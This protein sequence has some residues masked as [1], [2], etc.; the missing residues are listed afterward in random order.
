MMRVW[1]G[2]D[3]PD[4]ELTGGSEWALIS[5]EGISS[6][7]VE[8]DAQ[9]VAG[10]D[11]TAVKSPKLSPRIIT[12]NF[13]LIGDAQSARRE[14]LARLEPK[15]KIFLKFEDGKTLSIEGYVQNLTVSQDEPTERLEARIYCPDP[16]FRGEE[17]VTPDRTS[18]Y[19]FQ[20]DAKGQGF[21]LELKTTRKTSASTVV[22]NGVSWGLLAQS[23]P[24]SGSSH[25]IILDTRSSPPAY[26][27]NGANYWVNWP[28]SVDLPELKESNSITVSSSYWHFTISYYIREWGF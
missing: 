8:F 17:I 10:R 6:A 14:L 18:S 3:Q 28:V 1:I 27:R 13:A 26:T 20:A 19:T 2:Y 25:T 5:A 15:R 21:K 7:D 11:G 24:S 16:W 9:R 22:F 23:T 4:F 12:L